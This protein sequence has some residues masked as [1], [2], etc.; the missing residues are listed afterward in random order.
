MEYY[1]KSANPQG[2]QEPLKH[3]LQKVSELAQEFGKPL[4]LDTVG[5]LAGQM[6]DFGK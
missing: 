2:Y 1:A 3:H 6:H 4:G 5:A